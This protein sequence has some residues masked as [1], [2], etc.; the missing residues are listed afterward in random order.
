MK[1][2]NNTKE[3]DTII[4]NINKVDKESIN[5]NSIHDEFKAKDNNKDSWEE[6]FYSHD[7]EQTQKKNTQNNEISSP[8]RNNT[9]NEDNNL[10]PILDGK[11]N[12]NTIKSHFNIKNLYL[13]PDMSNE[14]ELEKLI[15]NIFY[16]KYDMPLKYSKI[17]IDEN[18]IQES[19]VTYTCKIGFKYVTDAVKLYDKE[20]FIE[21]RLFPFKSGGYN[22]EPSSP[23]KNFVIAHKE[24]MKTKEKPV[25]PII[26]RK[27]M[28]SNSR[29]AY[30]KKDD[31]SS[32]NDRRQKDK[33]ADFNNNISNN[34]NTHY[35]FDVRNERDRET[36]DNRETR[37]TR[38]NRDTRE[39]RDTRDGRDVRDN[40]RE[41][42]RDYR[43][44]RDPRDARDILNN[45]REIKDIRDTR[46]T[47]E[48][49]EIR[50]KENKEKRR[51]RKSR[52]RSRSRRSTIS[53]MKSKGSS[54]Y[55]VNKHSPN[56]K[57]NKK[58]YAGYSR[59]SNE[60]YNSNN[61]HIRSVYIIGLAENCNMHILI[62]QLKLKGISPHTNIEC[63]PKVE[64]NFNNNYYKLSFENEKQCSKMIESNIELGS[65]VLLVLPCMNSVR[66]LI[67]LPS[68]YFVILSYILFICSEITR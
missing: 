39:N 23:F 65:N 68:Y 19:K 20:I 61:E 6:G 45:P 56:E 13:P 18:Q 52:S 37:D 49:R 55:N 5:N 14:N 3:I 35:G 62:N 32:S 11:Q 12:I 7:K 26:K 29:N 2:T 44:Q 48:A 25:L 4:S 21:Y 51:I 66:F 33:K 58:N 28:R 17:E 30:R 31:R 41:N 59:Y 63:I 43:E 46:E 15:M 16:N 50:D 60:N 54:Y 57:Y 67:L 24:R 64:D 27:R 10:A 34:R 38:D 1:D 42:N 40:N 47:R 9:S 36:R 8:E 53:S 22:F